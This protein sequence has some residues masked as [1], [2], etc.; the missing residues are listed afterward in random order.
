[1]INFKNVAENLGLVLI[2]IVTGVFIGHKTTLATSKAMVKEISPT[3]A[4]AIDKE[5][6]K[7]EIANELYVHKIKNSDSI[8]IKMDPINNQDP[9]NIISKDSDCIPINMLSKRELRRLKRS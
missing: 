8:V 4:L 6:I 3:I 9:T 5:T 2:S 1:M 7:N